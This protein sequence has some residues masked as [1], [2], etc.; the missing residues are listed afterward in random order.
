M[1]KKPSFCVFSFQKSLFCPSKDRFFVFQGTS[2]VGKTFSKV[3]L[4]V[5]ALIEERLSGPT[6]AKSCKIHMGS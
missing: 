6:S 5:K 4:K 1:R 2:A 3:C